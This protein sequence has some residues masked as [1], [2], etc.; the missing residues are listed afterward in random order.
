MVVIQANS[1]KKCLN[2]FSYYKHMKY[3]NAETED[4]SFV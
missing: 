1:F 3:S 2:V 4:I